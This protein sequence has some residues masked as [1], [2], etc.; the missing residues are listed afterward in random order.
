MFRNT[1][2]EVNLDAIADNVKRIQEICKK[3]IIAVLKADAYGCGDSHVARA[4]LSVGAE[5]IAVSSL[6]E[7]LMLRNEG[8]NGEL[9]ILGATE[10]EDVPILIKENIS[11]AAYSRD[12]VHQV[13]TT[14]CKN[15]KIHLKIDSGM[16]R[17]GFRT[18][19]EAKE[20]LN[21]L[22][23]QECIVDGI[24]TH[25]AC[26]DDP[27][28]TDTKKQFSKFESIVKELNYSFHWIHSDNSDATISFQDDLTNACRIG[29]GMYGVNSYGIE[30]RHPISL[31]TKVIMVKHVAK[32]DRIG[33]GFTYEAQ[34]DEIIATLPIGYADGLVR[35]NQ[36]RCVYIDGQYAT[37][38]GRICMDQVMV[39]LEKEVPIGTDVE[40]FGP[41]IHLE[42]MAKDLNTIPYEIICLISGR[43]TRS[44]IW[45]GKQQEENARILKSE[46]TEVHYE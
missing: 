16:N 28:Q 7:A 44:Y 42:D 33:Y 38:V 26:A 17:I 39:R 21:I 4:V 12:W 19:D 8:Y 37:I 32:G 2:M 6:D 10:K 11:V 46:I 14:N 22:L 41:H 35:A 29:I 13:Q 43:V 40:I 3:R 27:E 23:E 5:M 34:G 1:W 25:F 24:F 36:G 31:H 20:A 18:L 15:L 9:L 45:E 30:L